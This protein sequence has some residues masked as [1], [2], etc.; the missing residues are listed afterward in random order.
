[1]RYTKDGAAIPSHIRTTRR[2]GVDGHYQS[3]RLTKGHIV[4]V[5]YPE[6]NRNRSGREIEYI[7]SING[8][9]VPGVPDIRER[10][11]IYNYSERVRKKFDKSFEAKSARDPSTLPENTNAEIVYVLFLNG[12]EDFPIIIGA[13]EHPKHAEYT[14]ASKA[15]GEFHR[16]EFLGVEVKIDKDS[17]YTITQLGRRDANGK[18]ENEAAKGAIFKMHGTGE[19]ELIN[20]KGERFFLGED[21][22][23]L[24]E[25]TEPILLGNTTITDWDTYLGTAIAGILPGSPGQNAASLLAIKSAMTT[26]KGVLNSFK[27]PNSFTD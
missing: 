8:R 16:D 1:M 25:G 10:G 21:K 19:I 7:V 20:N 14:Q 17:N 11:A 12:D 15:D 24:G 22:Q 23:I 5:V 2:K 27:S 18:I 4:D 13:A 9:R 26:L 6:D 3:F